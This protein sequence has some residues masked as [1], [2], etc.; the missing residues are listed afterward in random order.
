MNCKAAY[1]IGIGGAG[2][3]AIARYLHNSGVMVSGY[4][5]T[6]TTLTDILQ[7][8]GIEINFTDVNGAIP[9]GILSLQAGELL[10]ITTP[11]VPSNNNQLCKLISM[12][13]TP[14]KRAELLGKITE[15]G[16]SIAIAGTHGKTST[17]AM[18]AHIL[19]GTPEGC[20]AFLGGI[21]ACNNSNIY[22]SN[23]AKWTVVEADEFD[24]SFHYLH[25]TN[26]LITSL[27]PDH[28]DV[29]GDEKSFVEAFEVFAS[30]IC[31]K[32][33]I[34][35]NVSISTPGA[36]RYGLVNEHEDSS[37]LTHYASSIE[38]HHNGIKC[39]LSLSNGEVKFENLRV[40]LYGEHNLENLVGAAALAHHAGTPA[41][42]IASRIESFSGIYR[43]F[44]IHTNRKDSVYIDD[45]AHHPTEIKKTIEAVKEHFPGRHLTV[46]FQPHL[47]SRTRDQLDGF[48]RELVECDR[49]ILLPI[50]A[51]RE[52]PIIGVNTQLI[53]DNISHPH[54]ETSTI[55][56]IFENLKAYSV[57]VILTMGAGDIDTIVPSLIEYTSMEA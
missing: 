29:Y 50:Y 18:L 26:G 48:S 37:N 40:P 46:I 12:G 49:L 23:Q 21:S 19:D 51:A 42:I 55:N 36:E 17:T 25:P 22:V 24:R 2:M 57:D 7:K 11:A 32:I 56:S 34:S 20:N 33:L 54:A 5:K 14:I 44:Q 3:S 43:R 47:Y 52:N 8:E 38:S 30:Q 39:S 10:L 1:L 53:L 27:D 35:K 45:Y 16:S 28:L 13:H 9:E 31:N 15:N 6:E 4:D 41:N